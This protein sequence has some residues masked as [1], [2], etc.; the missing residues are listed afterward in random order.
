MRLLGCDADK[1]EQGIYE[2]CISGQL[3]LENKDGARR[4]YLYN[5][6]KAE[7]AVAKMT[8]DLLSQAASTEFTGRSAET[9]ITETEDRLGKKTCKETERSGYMCP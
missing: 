4:M 5:F 2:F 9:M 7:N 6:Y 3:V 1:F 8:V